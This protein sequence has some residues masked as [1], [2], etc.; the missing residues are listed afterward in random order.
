M[1]AKKVKTSGVNFPVPQDDSEARETIREIGDANREITRIETELNDAIAELQLSFG[2]RVAPLRERVAGQIEGL[3]M[4]AQVNRERL[5]QGGRVKFHRFSTGEISWRLRPAKVT[6][7]GKDNVI[8][9]IKSAGL[10]EKFLRTKED[11]NKEAMLDDR[12]TAGTIQ[13]VSIGS[14]GEDFLVEPFETDLSSK[15]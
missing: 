10:G 14:D 15:A 3:R 2:E 13:G 12:G 1:A 8:S 5:T 11:I 4:Y 9:A 7:R 6:I